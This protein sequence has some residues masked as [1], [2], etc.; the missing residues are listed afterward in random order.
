MGV[1]ILP[2]AVNMKE[3][4][5]VP[6]GPGI[7]NTGKMRFCVALLLL[8]IG[9]TQKP[10]EHPNVAPEGNM[11]KLSLRDV[12]DGNVHFFT[13]RFEGKKINFLIRTDGRGKLHAH[14]DACY[15]CYKYKMGFKVEGREIVCIACRLRYNLDD[16]FWDFVGPC[17]PIPLR[18]K[19]R[20]DFLVIRLGDIQRGKRFF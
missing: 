8:V 9:C 7:W 18:S 14:Y 3:S 10:P 12:N 5:L 20:G 6:G 17:A 4:T 13:Y 2:D 11:I 19:V 15:S 1:Q 16:E